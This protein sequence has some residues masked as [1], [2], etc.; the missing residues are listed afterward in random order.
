MKGK[1]KR[2]FTADFKLKVVLEVLKGKETLATI[3]KRY[4]LHPNQIS[5]W[6]KLF[7]EQ[8][9]QLFEKPISLQTV[10]PE[11]DSALLYEQIGQLQMELTF[12]KKKLTP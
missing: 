4:E 1:T 2:K 12:L 10:P 3:S 8:A 11:T 6:K 5:D 9:H 7:L